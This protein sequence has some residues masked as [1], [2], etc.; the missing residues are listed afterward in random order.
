M[1]KSILFAVL[2]AATIFITSCSKDDSVEEVPPTITIADFTASVDENSTN[3]TGL[4]TISAT[5]DKG[6]LTFNI[7]SQVPQ[8]SLA[9]DPSSGKLTIADESAFDYETN[10]EITAVVN[11]VNGNTTK[12]ANVKITV[13]DIATIK[14]LLTDSEVVAYFPF[15]GNINDESTN[16]NNGTTSGTLTLTKDRFNQ[17]DKAYN[18]SAGNVKIPSFGTTNKFSISAWVKTSLSSHYEVIVSKGSREYVFRKNNEKY[19]GC[20]S[21]HFS[22]GSNQIASSQR[23]FTNAWIHV[24]MN[25]NDGA[26]TLFENGTQVASKTVNKINWSNGD[27]YI[28]AFVGGER[29]QGTIDDVLFTNRILTSA[30]ITAL[31]ADK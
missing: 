8:G 15:N 19:C 2:A 20:L 16:S 28:G 5:T 6:S 9:I 17:T 12:T 18:F 4:G 31:A 7:A 10:T 3:G 27:V 1:K 14:E 26:V 29:F 11:A 21:A 22:N 25:Y 24:V 13:N 23:G 30:E